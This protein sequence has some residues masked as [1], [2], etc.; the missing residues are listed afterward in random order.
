[1]TGEANRVADSTTDSDARTRRFAASRRA[2]PDH[3]APRVRDR[4]HQIQQ[5]CGDGVVICRAVSLRQIFDARAAA[6]T[7]APHREKRYLAPRRVAL[8]VTEDLFAR[9]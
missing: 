8:S 5:S 3:D 1:V 9:S 2:S 6:A 7:R 4:P